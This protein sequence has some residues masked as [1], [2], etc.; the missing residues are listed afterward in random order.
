MTGERMQLHSSTGRL[1]L[2]ACTVMPLVGLS[3]TVV[4]AVVLSARQGVVHVPIAPLVFAIPV[5][6]LVRWVRRN[7]TTVFASARGLELPKLKRTMPWTSVVDAQLVPLLG[8]GVMT[9]HRIT[10][11]DGTPPV[12]FYGQDGAEHTVRRFKAASGKARTLA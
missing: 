7:S 5:I 10:F 1:F 8:A 6:L 2:L 11:N 12:T 3:G 9:V 4:A